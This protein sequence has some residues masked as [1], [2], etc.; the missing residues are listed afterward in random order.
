MAFP[1]L[2]CVSFLLIPTLCRADWG[3]VF[4]LGLANLR[5]I[6]HNPQQI[7]QRNFSV[8]VSALI[9]QGFRPPHPQISRPKLSAF[10]LNFRFLAPK[11]FQTDFQLTPGGGGRSNFSF[12]LT[13]HPTLP[14]PSGSLWNFRTTISSRGKA[15]LTTHTPGCRN[16]RFGKRC[17][18]PPPKQVVLTKSAKILRLP[19]T[20]KNNTKTRD[21]A[22]QTPE[23][24][25]NDE[26]GGCHPKWPVP[27]WVR[28]SPP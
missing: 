18:Y 24:D 14:H 20:H 12:S 7:L 16:G 25:E 22:P 4:D 28:G 3:W 17:S 21:F 11:V 8:N 1:T 19:S 5:R 10:L 15:T 6:A 23:I 26:N 27:H 9:L 2:S 13:V